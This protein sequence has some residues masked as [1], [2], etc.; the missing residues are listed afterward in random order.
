[1]KIKSNLSSSV[2][3]GTIIVI[4]QYYTLLSGQWAL[5]TRLIYRNFCQKGPNIELLKKFGLHF[6]H[7]IL[8]KNLFDKILAV[9]GKSVKMHIWSLGHCVLLHEHYICEN[10]FL[11]NGYCKANPM[12]GHINLRVVSTIIYLPHSTIL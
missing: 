5:K 9:F 4:L 12:F 1:M 10:I 6:E 2:L 3:S 11:D 7:R 8:N